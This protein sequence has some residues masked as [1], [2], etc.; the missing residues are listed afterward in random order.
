MV[1]KKKVYYLS[2]CIYIK[3]WRDNSVSELEDHTHT[4]GGE[5]LQTKLQLWKKK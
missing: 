5:I 2:Y 1:T 3:I 4:L